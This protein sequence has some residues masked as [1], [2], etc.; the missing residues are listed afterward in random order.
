MNAKRIMSLWLALVFVFFSANS[1]TCQDANESQKK[2]ESLKLSVGN[3]LPVFESI[4]DTGRVW[5]STDHIGK[6]VVVMYFYPGDFTGGC[7]KQAEAY[8]DGLDKIESNCAL[9]V[10]VSGDEVATHK[11]FRETFGLKHALLADTK[12]ELANMLGIPIKKGGRVSAVTPDRKLM[13]DPDGNRILLERPVTLGRWT[14]V[15]DRDGKLASMREVKNP[16]TDIEEVVKIVESL[17]K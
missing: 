1:A 13:L 3:T 16:A 10:G 8:R 15:I 4:D 5:K 2:A 11:L 12:G 17:P 7:M 14:I 9:V 6:S